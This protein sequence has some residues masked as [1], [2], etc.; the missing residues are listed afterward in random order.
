M[1]RYFFGLAAAL[2]LAAST[3]CSSCC[4]PFDD[5]GPVW[6]GGQC[7]TECDGRAGS[8]FGGTVVTESPVATP[9]YY[10]GR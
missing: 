2:L 4:T 7:R 1:T 3:G 9:A 10:D 5:C 8:A 6:E